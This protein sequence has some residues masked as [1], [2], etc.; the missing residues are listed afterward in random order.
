M[1]CQ[2]NNQHS[3][4]NITNLALPANLDG[5]SN[6]ATTSTTFAAT[7][8]VLGQFSKIALL[9]GFRSIVAS[10]HVCVLLSVSTHP[11]L[12]SSS[13]P[14]CIGTEINTPPRH[15]LDSNRQLRNTG[16]MSVSWYTRKLKAY[17]VLTT[18]RKLN[19]VRI[20]S[21]P[22]RAIGGRDMSFKSYT[23]LTAL[24]YPHTYRRERI[25]QLYPF[26]YLFQYRSCWSQGFAWTRQSWR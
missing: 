25:L 23:S 7:Y 13:R 11:G 1:I 2:R 20:K 8:P 15:S 17:R 5:E 22:I 10:H 26:C 18:W 6:K 9:P 14:L 24:A 3:A 4:K 12:N 19:A 16:V 21:S